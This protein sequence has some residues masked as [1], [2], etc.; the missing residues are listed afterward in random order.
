MRAV[1]VAFAAFIGYNILIYTTWWATGADYMNLVGADVIASS[2]V[3]PLFLGTVFLALVISYLGWWQPVMR[4]DKPAQPR[5]TLW[6][7]L[8][9][10]IGFI[11]LNIG[12]TDW[13]Q[14]AF[15]HLIL[16][17]LAGIFVGFNE[18]ALTRGILIIGARGSA[19]KEVHVWFFSS[20]LFGALHVP[21]ALFGLP[22]WAALAQMCFAFL[23]GSGFYVLRRASGTILVPM[24][25]HGAWEF[26]T[27][28]KGASGADGNSRITL[29]QFGTYLV[30]IALVVLIL[31]YDRKEP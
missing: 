15:A 11:V 24:I 14:I 22:F 5:W 3:L 2:I 8:F 4:D 10:T 9:I 1:I 31:R 18:E 19:W 26:A 28:A 25:V 17:L 20:A 12:A 16:L 23:A 27:G 6:V 29:F 30:S 7:I 13:S 21:N